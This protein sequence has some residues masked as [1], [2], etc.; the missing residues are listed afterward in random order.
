MQTTRLALLVAACC[1]P[2]TA[3]AEVTRVEIATRQPYLNGRSF[4]G[5]GPYEVLRGRVHFE[6]DPRHRA[7]QAVVDLELAPRN[8]RGRVEFSA[9]LEILTPADP[10]RG[11]RVVLYDVNNRGNKV[12]LGQFNSGADEFLMRMGFTVVW[13]GWI[14]ETQPGGGR[15]RLSAPVATDNGQPI[16][17]RVRA[18]IVVDEARPKW[19][20]AMW[21]NQGSYE[22]TERGEREAVLTWRLRE[23]DER[24]VIPRSQWRLEKSWIE[25]DGQRGQLPH[26]DLVVAGGLQPGWIYELVYEAQGPLV[27]GLGLAGIRDL[28]SCLKYDR[29]E[30]NPVRLNS[31]EPAARYA[32]GFGVSQSGRCLRMF[33]YDGFNADEQGRQV[34]DGVIPHVAGA[35][36]GFFNH[37]FASPT[38]HNGQH[39]N[40]LFP[41]DMFPFTFGDEED[42]FTGR[43]DGILR[44]ARAQNVVPKVFH[45]QSSSEYWHRAGS[46]VHTDP[47]GQRD[48]VI[49]PEVRIY[50]FG[51]TQHG[52]GNGAPQPGGL[53]TLPRNPADYR[54]F[55][56][57]LLV[58]LDAWVREGKEPPPSVYP[59]IAEG[60]LVG[61][62]EHESGW[63]TLP[64]I[65]YPEVIHQPEYL[66]RGPDFL[67]LRRTL[68]EP[69]IRK[70]NYGVKVA[71]YSSDNQE[72]GMLDLPS[73]SVP[74][75]TH[76]SWN[77]R[78][79]NAGAEGELLG[80]AGGYVRFPRTAAERQALGDPRSALLERYQDFDDYLRQFSLAC[81]R[82]VKLRYVLEEDL[83]RLRALA[84]SRRQL[85]E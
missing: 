7:N 12:A 79:R 4:E 35:G 39:D 45:T 3:R 81:G 74:V 10:A 58:A 23:K 41:A 9:D 26:L 40:H 60:T 27:Q 84:E 57:A 80:L 24:V 38:R 21:A 44:R 75:G 47:L 42:P 50:S 85:F 15:L 72:R 34:F 76:T 43:V 2:A 77:L 68:I 29:S 61:W 83:P 25:V 73:V 46:L 51:G 22:P 28:V 16:A 63:K 49:P 54:P 66:D 65:R 17:G 69:P 70:G 48:A 32:Y 67:T 30:R 6:V 55:N 33:L 59:R 13:S 14:A 56:R 78:N 8:E 62:R 1:L 31:G 5:V 20:L 18:E 37:R 71:Q 82:L 36:L 64:A 53:G 11:R 52:P 19:T